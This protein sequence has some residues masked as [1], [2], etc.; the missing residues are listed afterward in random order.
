MGLGVILS[1]W[2][3]GLT[4]IGALLSRKTQPFSEKTL[5]VGINHNLGAQTVM[6]DSSSSEHRYRILVADDSDLVRDLVRAIIEKSLSADCSTARGLDEALKIVDDL[7]V[8]LALLDYNMPGM[9]GLDGVQ[10]IMSSGVRHVALLSGSISSEVVEEAVDLGVSGFL[11]KNLPPRAML[12]AI[13]AMC[14]GNR[15]PAQHFLG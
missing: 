9:D 2:I 8:D 6:L 3:V 5:Q 7:P 4:K 1:V 14:L 15:F 11:P 10:R 13:R 12:D